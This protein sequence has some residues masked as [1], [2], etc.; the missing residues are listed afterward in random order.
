MPCCAPGP[1]PGPPYGD[2]SAEASYGRGSYGGEPEPPERPDG[3]PHEEPKEA[4][5][6]D[7][8]SDLSSAGRKSG[9]PCG[10]G[11]SDGVR[12]SGDRVSSVI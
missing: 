5:G 2:R 3:S 11:E 4:G 12:P 6:S 1:G 7:R 10:S 9:R 8:C